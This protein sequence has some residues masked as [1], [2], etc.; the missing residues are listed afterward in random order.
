MD[1]ITIRLTNAGNV[2]I[3]K[4]E[5][6]QGGKTTGPLTVGEVIEQVLSL[7]PPGVSIPRRPHYSM[8][9]PDEPIAAPEDA[10]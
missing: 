10:T 6:L 2:S 1:E 4:L 3:C 7:L 8:K 5:V 9:A